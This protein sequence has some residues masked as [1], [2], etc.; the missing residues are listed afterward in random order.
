MRDACACELMCRRLLSDVCIY[1]VS[2]NA[3]LSVARNR[4][5]CAS[6]NLP[7]FLC[8]CRNLPHLFF[9]FKLLGLSDTLEVSTQWRVCRT[10]FSMVTLAVVKTSR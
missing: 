4:Q 1:S 3:S 7:I 6:R 8:A 5:L 2:R 9:S 10:K